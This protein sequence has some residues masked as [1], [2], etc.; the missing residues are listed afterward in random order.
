LTRIYI[1]KKGKKKK[2]PLG[3]PTMYDRAIQ[4]LYAMALDPIAET[5]A[6]KTLITKNRLR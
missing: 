1:E 6:D 2:R 4:A 5:T 3:I